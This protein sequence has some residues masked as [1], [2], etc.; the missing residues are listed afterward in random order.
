MAPP[1]TQKD[2]TKAVHKPDY[3]AVRK[4]SGPLLA[5]AVSRA[6]RSPPPAHVGV[7]QADRVPLACPA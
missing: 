2:A 3:D 6:T 7:A 5:F 4:V 1:Q